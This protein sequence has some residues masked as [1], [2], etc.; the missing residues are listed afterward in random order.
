M[1]LAAT[2]GGERRENDFYPTPPEPT[3]A[4]VPKLQHWPRKIWEPACGDGGIAKP[5]ERNGFQVVGTD[6]VDRGYGEG[7]LD[8]LAER[9]RRADAIITNP[10][11]GKLVTAFIEHALDLDVPY[12]A[13][14]LNVN[15]WHAAGRNKL[16]N[17][18]VPEAVYALCWRPDFTGSGSPYFNCVWTVWGPRSA[19]TTRYE[20]LLEPRMDATPRLPLDLDQFRREQEAARSLA[21]LQLRMQARA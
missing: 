21:A 18:R 20:R 15:L 16:W 17:R 5:L 19:T 3:I 14:L 2:N 10:P 12:I 7:G 4:L 8:F 13:M 9:T 1:I 6:L 11:F